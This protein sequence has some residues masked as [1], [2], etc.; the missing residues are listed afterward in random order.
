VVVE[1]VEHPA[2]VVVE[3]ELLEVLVVEELLKQNQTVEEQVIHLLQIRLKVI[4]V[5][6]DSLV[7]TLLTMR[8]VV[9]VEQPLL[10]L[11]LVQEQ[12]VTV[13]QEL[14]IQ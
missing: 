2:E 9:V 6:M 1:V 11:M 10:V 8:Q 4:L 13:E 7:L 14:L 3:M 5:V 12:V